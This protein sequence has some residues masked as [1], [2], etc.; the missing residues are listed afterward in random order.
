MISA[1][2]LRRKEFVARDVD[3]VSRAENHIIDAA[4]TA[5]IQRERDFIADGLRLGYSAI[6]SDLNGSQTCG[7]PARPSWPYGTFANAVAQLQRNAGNDLRIRHQTADSGRAYVVGRV[8]QVRKRAQIVQPR[9]VADQPQ[10]A[11]PHEE[12]D[13][14]PGFVNQGCR[15]E[16]ALPRANHGNALAGKAADVATLIAMQELLRRQVLEHCRAL[17]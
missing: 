9:S 8:Q 15:F 2:Q 4:L 13:L 16:R 12:F 5:I 1:H 7:K 11:A 10:I 14:R 3:I 6:R 17:A